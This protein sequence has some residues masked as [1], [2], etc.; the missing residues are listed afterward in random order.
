MFGGY[1]PTCKKES[2]FS[3]IGRQKN[4]DEPDL[5]LYNCLNSNCESTLCFDTIAEYNE[6]R[7]QE[8]KE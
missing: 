5:I 3:Y 8:I 2:E 4:L 1:C 7:L 6:K